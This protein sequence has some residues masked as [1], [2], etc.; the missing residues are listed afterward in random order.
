MKTLLPQH[1][2]SLQR[3]LDLFLLVVFCHTSCQQLTIPLHLQRAPALVQ[4]T[5]LT[6]Y[7]LCPCVEPRPSNSTGLFWPIQLSEAHAIE[8][9]TAG[10]PRVQSGC[11]C[12]STQ[13][14]RQISI[15]LHTS[16]VPIQTLFFALSLIQCCWDQ[17]PAI[18]HGKKYERQAVEDYT[19]AKS[20][21]QR[22]VET[23]Q[24]GI[25]LHPDM[26]YIG[27]SPDGMIYDGSACPKLDCSR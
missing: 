10:R 2:V 19:A 15:V 7:H 21:Q 27:A 14:H 8:T 22:P 23:R 18:Q 17:V 16:V 13:S 26:R 11:Y 12:T 4:T 5:V 20:A 9:R 6:S 3:H 25:A 1:C 24:C